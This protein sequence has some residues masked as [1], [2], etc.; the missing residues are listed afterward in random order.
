[1]SVAQFPR[2]IIAKEV[3]FPAAGTATKAL[4]DGQIAF[5]DATTK[6]SVTAVSGAVSADGNA[7]DLFVAQ[8]SGNPKTGTIKSYVMRAKDIQSVYKKAYTAPVNQVSYVGFDGSDTTKTLSFLCET[9]YSIGIRLESEEIN[10]YF[11]NPGIFRPVSVTTPCCEDC[12]AGCTPVDCTQPTLDLVR[13]INADQ[14]L[15]Q[16]LT[17][18]GV[19]ASYVSAVM[20]TDGTYTATSA[21]SFT[22]VNGDQ[23]ISVPETSNNNDAGKYDTD[24]ST[25]A[26]GDLLR[27]GSS[28]AT[29][30]VYQVIEV[31]G[32]VN[33]TFLV[34]LHTPYQGSSGTVSAANVGVITA[35]T[36]CGI[37]ITG[38][39][40]NPST[41]CACEPLFLL[42][43]PTIFKL[44]PGAGWECMTDPSGDGT[45]D[46]F[47][48]YSVDAVLGNGSGAEIYNLENEVL[49]YSF[50]RET[51]GY[52][53]R[54]QL[55]LNRFAV[56]AT[57]Y[58]QYWIRFKY[59]YDSGTVLGGQ[60]DTHY[61]IIAVPQGGSLA[62][63]MDTFLNAWIIA[64]PIS[65]PQI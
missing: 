20:V 31:G 16:G 61:T 19:P 21:G 64:E 46:G 17:N 41:G 51:F 26:V 62:S 22:V 34:K 27:I 14:Y 58:D 55:G 36:V 54:Y 59:R 47:I 4:T 52:D 32:S 60:A 50:K 43:K 37:K 65:L 35:S 42:R 63:A 11:G 24:G 40:F 7:A 8:Y 18:S 45:F 5:F 28:A 1:M 56:A 10:N 38:G 23:W 30:P 39:Y 25:I 13:H 44:S 48:T 12:T 15:N 9:D 6:L 49:G 2:L 33:N 57:N 53:P 29:S 3:A